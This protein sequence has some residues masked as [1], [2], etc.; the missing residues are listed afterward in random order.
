MIRDTISSPSDLTSTRRYESRPEE[1]FYR[2]PARV[3]T[4]PESA[5]NEVNFKEIPQEICTTI[6]KVVNQLDIISSTLAILEQR[7][8][9]NESQ[10]SFVTQFLRSLKTP[11]SPHT[12]SPLQYM[13]ETDE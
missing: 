4:I 5:L 3:E 9:Q 8:Q 13:R 12:F 6:S 7:I 10:T 2:Q 11:I 1:E